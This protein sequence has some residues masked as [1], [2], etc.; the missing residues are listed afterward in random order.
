MR[1]FRKAYREEKNNNLRTI[2]TLIWNNWTQK[3]ITFVNICKLFFRGTFKLVIHTVKIKLN[4]RQEDLFTSFPINSCLLFSHCHMSLSLP[5]LSI[6]RTGGVKSLPS[7]I[8][9]LWKQV[10]GSHDPQINKCQ[11]ENKK[12]NT[13]GKVRKH[14]LAILISLSSQSA[15]VSILWFLQINNQN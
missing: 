4:R 15:S 13:Q 9:W 10:I 7:N 2:P 8:K 14:S 3:S 11:S 6:W 1:H 12:K 5:H